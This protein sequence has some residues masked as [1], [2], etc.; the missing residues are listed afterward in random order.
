M[1]NNNKQ[2]AGNKRW[3]ITIKLVWKLYQYY[4][5]VGLIDFWMSGSD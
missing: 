2:Q 4:R 1:D 5:D 3:Y